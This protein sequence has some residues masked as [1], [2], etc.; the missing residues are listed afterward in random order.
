VH[1]GGSSENNVERETIDDV[2]PSVAPHAGETAREVR[3]PRD[4]ADPFARTIDD[5]RVATEIDRPSPRPATEPVRLQHYEIIRQLDQGGMG[6]ISLARDMRL[7]RLVAIKSLQKYSGDGA[8]RFL[9]EA[10]ATANISHENIVV[11]HD[12]GEHD[13]KPYMVLEYLKGKTLKQILAERKSRMEDAVREAQRSS[14]TPS[15]K[16]RSMGLPPDRVVELM[17]PVV[18]ALVCAHQHGIVHRDLKPSN[19]LVT[20]TGV[21]KVLDFG[22]AKLLHTKHDEHDEQH[23]HDEHQ[24]ESGADELRHAS[25]GSHGLTR[26]GALIG[27]LPYMAPEQW[28]SGEIEP[29]TDLWAVGIMLAELVLGEHPLGALSMDVLV[30]VVDLDIPMPS[31]R[32][33]APELG[34][35]GSIIDRCLIKPTDKRLGN[36]EELLA[37]LLGL[38]AV[39]RSKANEEECP[40]LGLTSFKE[41]DAER[42][43]GRSRAMTEVAARLAEQPILAIVGPSGAGKSSF[44]RA[45]VVPTLERGGDAWEAFTIRPG[46]HP[47]V[48]LAELLLGRSLQT[49][50]TKISAFSAEL[51]GHALM[52]RERLAARL[53]A[54]PGYFGTQLRAWA[55][56]RLKRILLLV[57]Q[58]EEV[59]TMAPE[60]DRAAFFGCIAGAADDAGS[61]L[62]VVLTIRADFLDRVTEAHAAMIGLGRGMWLLPP[63]EREGLREAL[64]RPLSDLGYHFE[65][66]E[67]VE[68][69]LDALDHTS[70]ALPILSF[71][72]AKLWEQR[73][74]TRRVLTEESY[75]SIGGIAGTLAGHADAVLG[76]MSAEERKICRSVFLRLVTPEQTR[77]LCTL[78]DFRERSTERADL[79]RVLS[80]L[81]DARLLTVTGGDD[82]DATVEIVHE[83]LISRWPTLSRWVQ[84]NHVDAAFL[85]RIRSAARE[86]EK[87]ERSEDLLWRGRAADDARRWYES[88]GGEVAPATEPYLRAMIAYAERQ[89][90]R[91]RRVVGGTIGMLAAIAVVVS[92]LAIRADDAAAQARAQAARAQEAATR[93]DEAS[94]HAQEEARH[95]RNAVRMLAA[96]IQEGDPT[97]ALAVLREVEPPDV[98][99]GWEQSTRSMLQR[100]V[101][102]VVIPH[103]A[104][105]YSAA[106]SPD[107]QRIATASIDKKVRIWR[108]DGVGEPQILTGHEDAVIA[109]V[110]SPDGRSLLTASTDKTARVFLADSGVEA[111]VLRGHEREIVA[112]AW[113][114][115]GA[116]IATASA[117]GTARVWSADEGRELAVFRGHGGRVNA[118]AWSPDGKRIATGSDDRTVRVWSADGAEAVFVFRDH[119]DA[120]LS[121]SWSPDSERIASASNDKMARVWRVEGTGI[122]LVFRGHQA[123][124]YAV[125]WSPDGER[126]VTASSDKTAR[127]WPSDGRGEPLVFRADAEFNV[128]EWSHDGK[129]IVT[130][131]SDFTARVWSTEF[132]SQRVILRGH[133]ALVFSV[134]WSPDGSHLASTSEDGTARIWS[135]ADGR[136]TAVLRGHKARVA[137]TAWSPDGKRLVTASWDRTAR[138]WSAEGSAEPLMIFRDHTDEVFGAAWSHDGDHIATSSKDRTVRIW[139]PDGGE[140]PVVL[141]GPEGVVFSVAFSPDDRWIAA[142]SR[143]GTAWIW[144]TDGSG[145]PVVLRGHEERVFGVA[146]SPDGSRVVTTSQ[147][148][149]A[150]IWRADGGG[151]PVVLRGHTDWV[152]S[153]AWSADGSRI[154]T[155]SQDKTVRMWR[156]DGTGEPWILFSGA[157]AY[158][159]AAL[160]PDGTR[161]AAASD[162]GTVWVTNDVAPLAGPLDARLWAAPAYCPSI[163]QRRRQFTIEESAARTQMD[164]CLRRIEAARAP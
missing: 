106:W 157:S 124:I 87:S 160:S 36:A 48:A 133:G 141:R 24:G 131:S 112:A 84:E 163:E 120:V 93:A 82:A 148:K 100:G 21:V 153:A 54:E 10:R 99:A 108:A 6:T 30:D 104:L 18:R 154:V 47:L 123:K 7:G 136:E 71:T 85:A 116:R 49:L 152:R 16:R 149:T 79:E 114:P 28:R 17:I 13:G 11:I 90:T 70:G 126:L 75:R 144:R 135:V 57:D 60:G 109:V 29:G 130:A 53:R 156:A 44:V 73:D 134:A 40:Y 63:M 97:L 39:R 143:D 62:R 162:D 22:I 122:P 31:M 12:V 105:I 91:R 140:E 35:L 74:R 55:R 58:L 37:E 89:R 2:D 51:E 78:S 113:S 127:V 43:F 159:N 26:D 66:P 80:R 161:V 64:V 150:R 20:D 68:Q 65:P 33:L 32:E 77:A 3:A 147:D 155:A 1:R 42:Y 59:Y 4:R 15:G 117:D 41:S 86:W 19:I 46:A 52:E 115:D 139:R 111:L 95:A 25:A 27:T 151:A 118:V 164:A 129:R 45:G 61:P 9:I 72:A 67:L 83:S 23:E 132:M 14:A 137:T 69:M 81:I 76:A 92:S 50:A 125:R 88:Y 98:P 8:W 96:R 34:K 38:V 158:N 145:A 101:A 107:D 56:Q 102:R 119:E 94:A 103:P 5:G 121:V 110:W 128:A 142:T 146:W 138:V